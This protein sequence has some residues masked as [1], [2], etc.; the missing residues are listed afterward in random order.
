MKSDW[1]RRLAC[2]CAAQYIRLVW[3][4]SRWQTTGDDAAQRYW[5]TGRPFI[6]AFWHGRLLMMPK[7]WPR[8]KQMKM[9]ISF[10][11]DG[12]LIANTIGH[13]G[14]GA[15]RGSAARE[16]KD[17][18]KG[19]A[20]AMRAMLKALSSGDYVG[21]TPDG[22]RGPRMRASEGIV[23]LARL[24]GVPI[25]PVAAA[26]SRCRILGSWDRFLFCL[27]FSS[28]FFVWGQPIHVARKLD[29]G[30]LALSL[31]QIEAALNRVSEAADKLAGL[32]PI[33]PAPAP[34]SGPTVETTPVDTA[35]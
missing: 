28:G 35:S 11:R 21:I 19:G 31:K 20:G 12:E 9:L 27:P 29:A 32:P 1:L 34:A 22:P 4:T 7:C 8:D 23:S 33:P 24:S 16:G 17:K 30:Q 25:I 5:Q 3:A 13:F 18:D 14:L 15:I 26:T 6:L 10:H 2:W